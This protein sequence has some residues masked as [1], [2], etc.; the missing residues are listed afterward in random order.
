MHE[1]IAYKIRSAIIVPISLSFGAVYFAVTSS[2]WTLVALPFIFLGSLCAAPNFN[3][4]DGFLAIVASIAGLV[5]AVYF[6]DIGNS[7][8]LG[9][10]VSWFLSSIEK[11][12]RA[13]PVYKEKSSAPNNRPGL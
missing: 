7:I 4:A 9:T 2:A 8:F 3:L 10:I 1:P 11:R 6:Q 12:Q 5:V 13:V